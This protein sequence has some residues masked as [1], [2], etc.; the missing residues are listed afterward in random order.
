MRKIDFSQIGGYPLAQDDLG[1]LQGAYTECL[2]AMA[3]ICNSGGAPVIIT[4]MAVSGGGNT[5]SDGWL[6]YNGELVKFAGGTVAPAGGEV[7]MVNIVTN[8]TSL[9]FTNGLSHDVLIEITAVLISSAP[10]TDATHFPV[11]ALV[12]W[13]AYDPTLYSAV[14]AINT[15]ITTLNKIFNVWDNE[16]TAPTITVIGG[17]AFTGTSIGYNKYRRTGHTMI[18]QFKLTGTIAGTVNYLKITPPVNFYTGG[19]TWTNPHVYLCTYS[20]GGS[21]VEM[22][23]VTVD[24]GGTPVLYLRPMGATTAAFPTGTLIMDVY[25]LAETT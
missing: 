15:Q 14:T 2:K 25:L 4:G 13:T 9:A 19:G 6:Y 23:A 16:L 5:V 11:S 24:L 22:Q 3:S 8:T 21:I 7:A 18:W 12:P 17:G 1:Y 20:Q 10:V